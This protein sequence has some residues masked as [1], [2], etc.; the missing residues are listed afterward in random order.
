M[1]GCALTELAPPHQATREGSW[2]KPRAL[3]V[4][5]TGAARHYDA[6]AETVQRQGELRPGRG[7]IQPATGTNRCVRPSL[8]P[9]AAGC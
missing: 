4:H 9:D 7:S 6:G 5:G 3:T 1:A 8:R 2:R